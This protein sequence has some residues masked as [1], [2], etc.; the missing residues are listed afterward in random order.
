MNYR[1]YSFDVFDTVIS[2]ITATPAGIFSLIQHRLISQEYTVDFQDGLKQNFVEIRVLA[3]QTIRNT[4]KKEEITLNEIYQYIGLTYQLSVNDIKKLIEIEETEELRSVFGIPG[5]IKKINDLRNE[6]IKIIFISDTYLSG[7]IIR[8][9]LEKVGAINENDMLFVSSEY[10]VTKETGN[11]FRHI[12]N[13]CRCLPYEIFHTGDNEKSDYQIPRKMGISCNRFNDSQLTRYEHLLLKSEDNGCNNLQLQLLSGF[14][15]KLRLTNVDYT[16]T[17]ETILYNIGAKIAGPILL[18]YVLWILNEGKKREVKT[19]YFI[20]R[21]G[22]ILHQIA[23]KLQKKIA[24]DI[25]LRYLYGSR[26]AWHL[27]AI[28]NI[29]EREYNWIFEADPFLTIDIIAKRLGLSSDLI[30]DE[31]K[32]TSDNDWKSDKK[33]THSDIQRV[34]KAIGEPDL[35][36]K[37]QNKAEQC[38]RPLVEYLKQERLWDNEQWLLVDLGWK[39]RLQDSLESVFRLSG[40]HRQLCGLYFGLHDSVSPSNHNKK[41]YFFYPGCNFQNKRIGSEFV[42]FLEMFTAADHG[43]V[44]SYYFDSTTHAWEPRLI[45]RVNHEVICWGLPPLRSGIQKYAE[46]SLNYLDYFTVDNPD[47]FIDI[48]FIIMKNI[49]CNPDTNEAS[50]LGQFPHTSDQAGS[51][52]RQFAPPF[53]VQTVINL[54]LKKSVTLGEITYWERGS[55]IQSNF[56]VKLLISGYKKIR[57]F[58]REF[59]MKTKRNKK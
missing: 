12:L 34:K 38:R 10:G 1:Y 50:I 22:Q 42:N 36:K 28:K 40:N 11:L 16:D 55:Y 47:L 39:G 14:C 17:D 58:K 59:T 19:I 25:E 33:L 54:Y 18:G 44:L 53:T 41:A 9:M 51:H 35:L 45:E 46:E 26:Q 57:G 37:I 56:L 20:A 13:I 2:R 7:D 29:G 5:I 15:R 43:G 48:S 27:P 3:E 31:L 49:M 52:L 23:Q 24:P 8:Q 30:I 21:D 4:S 32:K 6:G